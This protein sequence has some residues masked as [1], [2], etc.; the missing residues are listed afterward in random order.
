MLARMSALLARLGEA[1]TTLPCPECRA[2]MRPRDDAPIPGRTA[3]VDRVYE[4]RGCGHRITCPS[5]W[6][7]PD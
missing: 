2:P 5:L 4:C 7:I 3:I 6:V 1:W